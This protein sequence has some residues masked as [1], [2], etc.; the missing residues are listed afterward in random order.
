LDQK[1]SNVL[2]RNLEENRSSVM[3]LS[4][5]PVSMVPWDYVNKASIH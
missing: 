5:P 1:D 3:G 2:E 4:E